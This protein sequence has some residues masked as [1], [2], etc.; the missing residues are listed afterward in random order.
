MLAGPLHSARQ[1]LR[2]IQAFK[3][4]SRPL[5]ERKPFELVARLQ[6]VAGGALQLFRDA[7]RR[8]MH[9]ELADALRQPTQMLREQRRL[10]DLGGG[11]IRLGQMHHGILRGRLQRLC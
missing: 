5:H 4:F 9:E 6:A 8:R 10:G 7:L 2:K 11:Q 3:H 1:R